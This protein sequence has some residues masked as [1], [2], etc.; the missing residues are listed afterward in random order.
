[1]A[2]KEIEDEN[3]SELTK[4]LV[5]DDNFKLILDLMLWQ[6][7]FIS[8]MRKSSSV[9]SESNDILDAEFLEETNG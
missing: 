2:E 1:M 8:D 6:M 5:S 3:F 7:T 4:F 9:V